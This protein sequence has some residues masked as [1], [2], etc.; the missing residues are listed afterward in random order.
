MQKRHQVLVFIIYGEMRE[1]YIFLALFTEKPQ[2]FSFGTMLAKQ[3]GERNGR[4]PE[5]F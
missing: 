4:L 1:D 5:S 2:L 3:I